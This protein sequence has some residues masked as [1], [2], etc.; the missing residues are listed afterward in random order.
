[1]SQS[2]N[3]AANQSTVEGCLVRRQ[4]DYYLL[5]D[6]GGQPIKLNSTQD[7]GQ[8]VDHH[9]RV[10][11][12]NNYSANNAAENSAKT[13]EANTAGETGRQKQNSANN[14]NGNTATGQYGNQANQ[15]QYGNQTNHQYGNN[16]NSGIENRTQNNQEL[17][18]A[19]VETIS[20]TCPARSNN[21]NPG[22]R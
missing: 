13:G 7:L 2:G 14:P 10:Q 9:V 3:N 4:T 21:A 12:Q 5:P 17:T 20:E 19:E 15:G 1:M 18:V 22:R 8:N 11:G 16:A 6:N